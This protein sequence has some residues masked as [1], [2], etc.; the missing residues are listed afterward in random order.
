MVHLSFSMVVALKKLNKLFLTK[1]AIHG[2]FLYMKPFTAISLSDDM[3][4]NLN[5]LGY[6]TMTPIQEVSIPHIL[7]GRDVMAQAKTGSGK[8]A[9]FG[10][11]LLENLDVAQ[12]RVQ[13]LILCPTRELAQQVCEELRRLARFRHNIK[14][15]KLTGGVP[16]K[17]QEHSLSH[18]A[19]IIVGTPGRISKLLQRKS[20]SF[21][22][23]K[24]L[25]LDEADRM[26]DMGFIEQIED[27]IM[28]APAKR[29][30]LNFSATFPQGI[31][32]LSQKFQNNPQELKVESFHSQGVIAQE[33][34]R[35]PPR[36]RTEA[37]IS[38][39]NNY[40]PTNAI[41]F[42]NTKDV[43][44]RVNNALNKLGFHSQALHGDLEQKDR[45]EVLLRFA[46]KSSRILVATDVAARG[47]DIDNLEAVVNYDFPFEQETYIHRIGRTGR[48]G[49]RGK[50]LTLIKE[51]EEFRVE[52]L[53]SMTQTPHTIQDFTAFHS[54]VSREDL[55]SYA[56][57]MVTLSV[58]G[59]RKN[60]ISPGDLVGA[61]TAEAA[62]GPEDIGK[63][64]RQ[65]F[66]TFVAVSRAKAT[67]A[68]TILEKNPIKGRFFKVMLH[69]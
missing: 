4:R 34:F 47:L 69:S 14:I 26:L 35:V 13:A 7:K 5:N 45:T 22:H 8:T 42:C 9:A 17:Q 25:V 11:G 1:E 2:S 38:W 37:L 18:Q 52:D 41:V 23:L 60:K 67:K 49:Q 40:R 32:D 19:H 55:E 16:L 63:I 29:Q 30:T 44:R 51:G 28:Q 3:L 27:I 31:K 66:L 68:L 36:M 56:P 48:A 6:L 62:L 65:D 12:F 50:A 53:S 54:E 33:F 15:L 20:L 10:I 39:L 61:L 24:T 43:C 64:D 58:N 57:E 59:G 46:N 21:D